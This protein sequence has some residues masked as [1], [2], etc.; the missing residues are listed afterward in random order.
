MYFLRLV[1]GTAP[2]MGKVYYCSALCDKYFRL[3]KTTKDIP[4]LATIIKI[5]MKRWKRWHRP[6]HTLAHAL[7][8][9]YQT[10]TLNASENRDV[11]DA[12]KKLYPDNWDD[13]KVELQRFKNNAGVLICS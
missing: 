2:T 3:V 10:H 12:L 8:P 1:D 11:K 13:I 4:W 7:D 6:I 5:F 9:S